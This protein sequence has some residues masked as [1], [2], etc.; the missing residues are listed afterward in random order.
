MRPATASLLTVGVPASSS[1]IQ[2]NNPDGAAGVTDDLRSN[3]TRH[4]CDLLDRALDALDSPA[5]W[6]RSH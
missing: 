3:G 2:S 1:V 4:L 5:P 6:F